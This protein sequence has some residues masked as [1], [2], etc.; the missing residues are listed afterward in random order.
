MKLKRCS[1][2]GDEKTLES[3]SKHKSCKGGRHTQCKSCVNERNKE[4]YSQNPTPSKKANQEYYRRLKSHILQAYGGK[5]QCPSGL[6]DERRPEFLAIDHIHGGGSAERLVVGHGPHMYRHVIRQ[7]CPKD[8]YR[9]LC[10]N[11][12]TALGHHHYCPHERERDVH[13]SRAQVGLLDHDRENS[14]LV[15]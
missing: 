4:R 12:N 3:F 15:P 11:C 2:C 7:G 6:C 9:L 13:V 5:C 8:K 14:C 1:K 10:H